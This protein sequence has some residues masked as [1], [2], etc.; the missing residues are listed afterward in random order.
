MEAGFKQVY[1]KAPFSC[2]YG[3]SLECIGDVV[4]PLILMRTLDH[5]CSSIRSTVGLIKQLPV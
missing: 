2:V 5:T 3:K 4:S 1:S